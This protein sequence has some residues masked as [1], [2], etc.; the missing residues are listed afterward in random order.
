[1]RSPQRRGKAGRGGPASKQTQPAKPKAAKPA[2]PS[3]SGEEALA[4]AVGLEESPNG[5]YLCSTEHLDGTEQTLRV[6]DGKYVLETSRVELRDGREWLSWDQWS[7]RHPGI[8]PWGIHGGCTR[9][10]GL[11]TKTLTR[12]EVV[13]WLDKN[14][15]SVVIPPDFVEEFRPAGVAW[16]TTADD[17]R[18]SFYDLAGLA[19]KHCGDGEEL[20]GCSISLMHIATALGLKEEAALAAKIINC[21][22]AAT[23]AANGLAGIIEAGLM[24]E[25]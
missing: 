1:M 24:G 4:A 7:E 14:R 20:A 25:L 3:Q 11:S 12:Q 21:H 13:A 19:L 16:K 6:Q 15:G 23:S 8:A 10:T 9:Q 18:K 17:A 22:N 2:K 5:E